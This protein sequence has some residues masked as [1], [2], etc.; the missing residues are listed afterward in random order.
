MAS[1]NEIAQR[2]GHTAKRAKMLEGLK[3]ALLIFKHAGC[4]IVYLDGS[5]VTSKVEPKDYDCCWEDMGVNL[6][7]IEDK[8]LLDTS[9]KS[10][11]KQKMLYG[12]EFWPNSRA[13]ENAGRSMFAFFQR[14]REGRRK[15]IIG[16]NLGNL[17]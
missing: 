5:F 4:I 16:I 1:W 6:D 13:I 2:F 15:G 3:K 9:E 12:G 14:D 7:M 17:E 8:C 10:R 11:T